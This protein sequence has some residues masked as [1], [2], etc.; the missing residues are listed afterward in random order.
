MI[1]ARPSSITKT[2]IYH[3]AWLVS[4][5]KNALHDTNTFIISFLL[6][7]LFLIQN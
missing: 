3:S 7:I 4:D 5:K 2:G 1:G 6:H